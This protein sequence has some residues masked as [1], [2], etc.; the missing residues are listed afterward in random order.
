M[1][2]NNHFRRNKQSRISNKAGFAPGTVTY[3]GEERNF[4]VVAD[5]LTWDDEYFDEKK[6]VS[7]QHIHDDISNTQTR[8]INVIGIHDISAIEQ[9]G[10]VYNFHS[11]VQEDIAHAT[12]RPKLDDYEDYL[13]VVAK[14]I[15]FDQIEKTIKTEQLSIILRGNTILSFIEDEGDL[16]DGLRDRIRKGNLKLRKSGSD[17]IMY[18]LLDAIVDNYF[19]VLEGIGDQLEEAEINL[20]SN[21]KSSDLS[22]LHELKRELIFLRKSIWPMREVIGVLSKSENLHLTGNTSIYLRDVYD[23]CVHAIDTLETYRDLISGMMDVYLS[24]LSNKMNEVM[25]TLTVISTIFIPLTF[26]VGVYGMNF[27]NM[28][29]IEDT[30]WGYRIIWAFMLTIGIGMG[31]YFKRKRWF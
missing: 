10:R 17:Y 20:L 25:K 27:K 6:G 23:H 14:M 28:P 16:F 2:R 31:I 11:L 21:A 4:H 8:W 3:T 5:V 30:T 29:E 26:I 12:Q 15:D 22:V 19:V 9:L 13:Y 7:I 24:S 1:K 18:C